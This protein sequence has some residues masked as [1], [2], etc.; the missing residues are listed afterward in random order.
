MI[1]VRAKYDGKDLILKESLDIPAGEE[2][3]VTVD[4]GKPYKPA[5]DPHPD[6]MTALFHAES[7]DEKDALH[8]DPLDAVAPDLVRTFGSAKGQFE[9]PDDF[10]DIPLSDM[11][12]PDEDAKDAA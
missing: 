7:I 11:G 2:V 8:I 5:F 10:K 6:P 1:Q 4:D 9:V 3:T 12:F